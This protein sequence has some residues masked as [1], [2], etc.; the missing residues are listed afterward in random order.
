MI[1]NTTKNARRI[2]G[3]SHFNS[4]S[5]CVSRDRKVEESSEEEKKD[6]KKKKKKKDTSDKR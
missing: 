2:N 3:N 5:H 6:K 1:E 4:M